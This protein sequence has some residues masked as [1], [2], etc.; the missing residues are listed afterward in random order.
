MSDSE[1]KEN[2]VPPVGEP[3]KTISQQGDDFKN[4]GPEKK[5]SKSPGYR[6]FYNATFSPLTFNYSPPR[7]VVVADLRPIT[8]TVP[9]GG[10]IR[11]P[12]GHAERLLNLSIVKRF[13]DS[14]SVSVD[15]PPKA[16][17]VRPSEPKPDGVFAD[18][19]KV[20][21]KTQERG[22]EAIV[23]KSDITQI[24]VGG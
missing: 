16:N 1:K 18:A 10:H 7:E 13:I 4:K 3:P 2:G 24:P 19:N 12:E 15:A 20:G 23:T 5:Q 8:Y 14:G 21:S 9:P 11:I 22:R 17:I 6:I